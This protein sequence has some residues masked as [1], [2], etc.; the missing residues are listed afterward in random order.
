MCIYVYLCFF[1]GIVYFIMRVSFCMFVSL[2]ACVC[3]RRG[4]SDTRVFASPEFRVAYST[5][6]WDI[7]AR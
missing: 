3:G 4:W 7:C 1:C 6:V 5:T 2:F